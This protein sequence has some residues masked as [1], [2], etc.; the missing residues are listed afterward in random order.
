LKAR[1]F[2]RVISR[3]VVPVVAY[4]VGQGRR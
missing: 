2:G 3:P 1:G 4:H